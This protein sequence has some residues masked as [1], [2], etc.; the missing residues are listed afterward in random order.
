[1]W[2]CLPTYTLT[3]E[4]RVV[5]SPAEAVGGV[6]AVTAWARAF[7]LRESP[8]RQGVREWEGMVGTV[9]V[10]L[11][12]AEDRATDYDG[13]APRRRR[14]VQSVRMTGTSPLAC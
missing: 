4:W 6:E 7:E 2:R 12:V 5:G 11:H 13:R 1:M 9:H 8:P 10:R 3:V 14:A